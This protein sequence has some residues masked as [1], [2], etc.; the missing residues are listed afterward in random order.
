MSGTF[1]TV[2]QLIYLTAASCFVLGLHM[3]NNPAT[4][5]RGNQVSV[6]GMAAAIVATGALVIHGGLIDA[7]GWIVIGAGILVGGG[8]GLYTARTVKMTAMPQL[9]SV[10][11]A[12]GGGAAALVAIRDFMTVG[13]GVGAATSVPTVLD[14]IIG[15]VTF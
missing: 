6:A 12:V 1:N 13:A 5:R 10:F 4:A 8:L 14:V 7:T 3:M 11:N 9:V 15:S 2:I